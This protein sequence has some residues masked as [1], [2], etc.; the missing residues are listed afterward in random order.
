METK[1][2]I[3]MQALEPYLDILDTIPRYGV[4]TYLSYPSELVVD[5][6]SSTQAHCTNRHMIAEAHRVLSDMPHVRH[7]EVRRQNLWLFETANAVIRFKKMDED[8]VSSNYPTKQARDFDE[9]NEL[10]GVPVAPTRLT[11]GYLLDATG[12]GYMRSQVSLPTKK[13]ALWCA[14]VIPIDV[15]EE[16]QTPWHEVTKQIFVV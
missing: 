16:N 5:H 12:T 6:D 1:I 14:A 4:D 8:G 15:R 11:F 13:G 9:G 3:I 7:I 10:L 2:E